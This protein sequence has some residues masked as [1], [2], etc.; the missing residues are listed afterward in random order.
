MDEEKNERVLCKDILYELKKDE[1]YIVKSMIFGDTR[2]RVELF[3]FFTPGKVT[4]VP[5]DVMMYIMAYLLKD[6]SSNTIQ[7]K[8]SCEDEEQDDPTYYLQVS[9]FIDANVKKETKG[10]PK[11]GQQLQ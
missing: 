5:Q 9:I 3:N 8:L 2:T 11:H 7:L 1:A 10:E 4:K 6:Y